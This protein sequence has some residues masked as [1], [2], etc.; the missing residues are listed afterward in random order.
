LAD[1]TNKT[2]NNKMVKTKLYRQEKLMES[3]DEM[4][5]VSQEAAKALTRRNEL[6]LEARLDGYTIRAI[7]EATGLS[8]AGVS[9]IATQQN[10][11]SLPVPRQKQAVT[12][13]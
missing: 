2:K 11:G 10:G 7:A 4:F 8:P 6:I 3:L 9:I 5:K 12:F 1:P 13:K